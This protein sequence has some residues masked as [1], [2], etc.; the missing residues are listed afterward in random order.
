MEIRVF[1]HSV[2]T[3]MKIRISFIMFYWSKWNIL[4]HKACMDVP[5]A[6]LMVTRV[7]WKCCVYSLSVW[8]LNDVSVSGS[9]SQKSI[10]AKVLSMRIITMY[11][12]TIPFVWGV[13]WV[14]IT[15]R[16]MKQPRQNF[17]LSCAQ[18]MFLKIYSIYILEFVD[19]RIWNRY[20][21]LHYL[22][23]SIFSQ[24]IGI[25]SS[26]YIIVSKVD[27]QPFSQAWETWNMHNFTASSWDYCI[28]LYFHQHLYH[29]VCFPSFKY[30]K[31][32]AIL[33]ITYIME[34]LM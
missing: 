33:W 17:I 28:P 8:L 25:I 23:Y 29:R 14:I 6:K 9:H 5:V 13:W 26:G 19:I 10:N 11:G 2:Y 4:W 31:C 27:V 12:Y 24:V 30:L 34:A 1:L 7:K 3:Y 16:M 22:T 18:A 20:C 32:I 15:C 21:Y